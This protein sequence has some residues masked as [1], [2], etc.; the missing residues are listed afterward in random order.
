MDS[1][2]K[3]S[4]DLKNEDFLVRCDAIEALSYLPAD[5]VYHLIIEMLDDRNYLVRCEAFDALKNFNVDNGL[6]VLIKHLK[7]ERSSMARM[8]AIATIRDLMEADNW[9]IEVV[10]DLKA[11]F[12]KEKSKGALIAYNTLRY[13]IDKDDKYIQNALDYLDDEDYHIRHN[14]INLLWD[15]IDE[16][17]AS[18]ILNEYKKRFRIEEARSVK[19]SLEEQIADIEKI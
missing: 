5:K 8:H 13:K 2:N 7:R 19:I 4:N 9:P 15:V 16:K 3:L 14:V 17:V 6:D 18:Q 1:I 12:A 11:M 10:L